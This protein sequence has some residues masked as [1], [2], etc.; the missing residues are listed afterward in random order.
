MTDIYYDCEFV[1]DGHTIDL[2]SIGMVADDGRE[3]YA[4]SP[5]FNF[6]S[7]ADNQWLIDNV[8]PSLPKVHGDARNHIPTRRFFGLFSRPRYKIL[9]DVFNR[10]A[11]EV[12]L[13]A[14]IAK[15]VSAFIAAT[16]D[17]QLWASYGAYDHVALAQLFGRMIDLPR[18]VP[19]WTNDLQQEAARLGV[20]ESDLPK[21][22]AGHHNALADARH[23][24][25]VARFLRER[26][27][28]LIYGGLT[29]AGYAASDLE[30]A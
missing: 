27:R 10:G 13:R 8:W 21:Q 16:P 5:Q 17:P 11:A 18:H 4:V 20:T 14:R 2:V 3:Y 9:R 26:R 15:E 22:A 25:D 30:E 6:K 29:Q 12:K 1:E 7:F 19:M 28:D 24:R 23:N